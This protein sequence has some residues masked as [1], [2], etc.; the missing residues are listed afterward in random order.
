M[1]PNPAIR[2][3]SAVLYAALALAAALAPLA[4]VEWAPSGLGMSYSFRSQPFEL[5]GLTGGALLLFAGVRAWRRL[6]WP[7][8]ASSRA[9]WRRDVPSFLPW[10]ARALRQPP[11]TP[12][13]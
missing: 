10:A 6:A 9:P 8:R 7:A 2:W 1:T 12:G 11:P 5:L 13:R 3:R 4:L